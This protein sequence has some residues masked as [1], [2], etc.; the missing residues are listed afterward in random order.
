MFHPRGV[1]LLCRL[2]ASIIL[3]PRENTPMT[4]VLLLCLLVVM[5]AAA[6]AQWIHQNP[7][8]T[9]FVLRDISWVAP[10]VMYAV[11]DAAHIHRSTDG[12]VTWTL[13][14]DANADIAA[15]PGTFTAVQALNDEVT[16]ALNLHGYIL[17]TM[18]GG[19]TWTVVSGPPFGFL[20][21]ITFFDSQYG[22]VVGGIGLVLHTI[23]GGR[24][25]NVADSIRGP[26]DV[27]GVA[28][29]SPTDWVVTKSDGSIHTT[30][31]QGRSWRQSTVLPAKKQNSL[32][33]VRFADSLRGVA[34]GTDGAAVTTDGGLTWAYQED[35]LTSEVLDVAH[36]AAGWVAVGRHGFIMRSDDGMSWQRV[37]SGT[38]QDLVAIS[39][40]DDVHGV[41]LGR[42]GTMLRTGDGGVRFTIMRDPPQPDLRAVSFCDTLHGTAVGLGGAVLHTSNGGATWVGRSS[43]TT[44]DLFTTVRASVGTALVAGRRE[45]HRTTDGGTTWSLRLAI[46]STFTRVVLKGAR[47]LAVD[48]RGGIHT[49][50]DTGA[51]W[52]AVN[53]G[54]PTELSAACIIDDD[55]WVVVGPRTVRFTDNAGADWTF[56]DGFTRPWMFDVTFL[57]RQTGW[58]LES[59]WLHRTTNGGAIFT[60]LAVN[61]TAT[62]LHFIDA[63]HGIMIDG[64]VI[65]HTSNGGSPWSTAR[66]L[67]PSR[68]YDVDVVDAG[69]AWVVG[70]DGAILTTRSVLPPVSVEAPEAS[71]PSWT[72]EAWPQPARGV[73]NV[74][75]RGDLRATVTLRLVDMLGRAVGGV[76]ER[77]PGAN[78]AVF[79][80]GMLPPGAYAIIASS[81]DAT[82]VHRILT[83]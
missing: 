2:H 24:S 5:P 18:N 38:T 1:S 31:D 60:R 36:T 28:M 34:V 42:T 62:R 9:S 6:P 11:G 50:T 80:V 12:G 66:Y 55:S 33:N 41:V 57:D 13:Q 43:P 68:L 63:Q 30:R 46:D 72:L 77:A 32:W 37:A 58:V 44:T 48:T 16:V 7:L 40:H 19:Q 74:A 39:F 65:D 22:V 69:H 20:Y 79:D 82:R 14:L 76:I 70:D 47:A 78:A 56:K 61:M 25:W 71:T 83:Y 4:R 73:L 59:G 15:N 53:Y 45:L 75:L 54:T 52:R 27:Y 81:P 26:G 35:L 49:S 67:T 23:D 21:N 29:R 8:P 17:R 51:T 3:P 64:T 10:S